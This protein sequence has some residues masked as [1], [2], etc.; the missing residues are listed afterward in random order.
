M[1]LSIT[2][3]TLGIFFVFSLYFQPLH[4]TGKVENKEEEFKE[5]DVLYAGSLLSVME[6]KI[7]SLFQNDS[8]YAY[9]G[10]GH[11]SIQNA[12]MVLDKQRTP[13][14]FISVG[15]KPMEMLAKAE[16]PIVK[17][18]IGFAAD[19]LVIAYNPKGK[20][21]DEFEKSK[22]GTVPWYQILSRPD[23]NFLRSDPTLDPKGCYTVIFT[24]LANIFYQNST[25]SSLILEGE[26]EGEGDKEWKNSNQIRPEEILMTLLETGEADA[27]PAYKHEAIERGLPY[28][29]LPHQINMGSPSFA[30]FYKQVSCTQRDGSLV[31]GK[32]IIFNITIPT[33]SAKNIKGGYEFVKFVLSN[34]VKNILE[35]NGFKT[36]DLVYKGDTY[37]MPKEI[38]SSK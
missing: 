10:E 19:E 4:I 31:E 15:D 30:D 20:F 11:G 29:S 34:K 38:T 9:R 16:P 1:K 35:G 14:V 32:P 17:W 7:G 2:L 27:V 24:K 6:K 36:I 5:V 13:D 23:V 22:S 28:I 21:K 26:G 12:N 8:G 25:L 18:Y 3:T 37:S 33:A